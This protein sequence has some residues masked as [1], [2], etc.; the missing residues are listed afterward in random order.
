MLLISGTLK[1]LYFRFLNSRINSVCK[2]SRIFNL[3]NKRFLKNFAG[4]YFCDFFVEN[5]RK[6]RN[7]RLVKILRNNVVILKITSVLCAIKL[8]F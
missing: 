3:A 8:A 1:N 4:F 7:L 6:S 5:L 2:I